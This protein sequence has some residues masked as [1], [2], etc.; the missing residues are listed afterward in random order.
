MLLVGSH[1]LTTGESAYV[2]GVVVSGEGERCPI[3]LPEVRARRA[4]AL[5]K[6]ALAQRSGFRVS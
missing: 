6:Y 3:E 2:V 5:I 1:G 4:R